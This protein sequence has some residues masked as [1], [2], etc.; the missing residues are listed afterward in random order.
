MGV[1]LARD[2]VS[3]RYFD[4]ITT[5][6]DAHSIERLALPKSLCKCKNSCNTK[7][8]ARILDYIRKP[9]EEL[10]ISSF[11]PFTDVV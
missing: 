10:L 11:V 3:L 4:G 8:F 9:I 5:E 7:L 2:P 6:Q 1:K